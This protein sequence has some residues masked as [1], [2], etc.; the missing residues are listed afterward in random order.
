MRRATAWVAKNRA[1]LQIEGLLRVLPQ[2]V[3]KCVF[4]TVKRCFA[5]VDPLRIGGLDALQ[6][7]IALEHE[8]CAKRLM[9]HL[10]SVHGLAQRI[11]VQ[12]TLKAQGNADVVG[13]AQRR[14]FVHEVKA[15]LCKRCRCLLFPLCV[16][17]TDRGF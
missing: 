8:V 10:Y 12:A 5:V 15:S 9:P 14:E 16:A 13:W 4:G 17:F 3:Q 7:F 11:V 2:H 1:L 6:N